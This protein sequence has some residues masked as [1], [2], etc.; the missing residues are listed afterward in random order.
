MEVRETT[1]NGITYRSRLEARWAV[2]FDK[3]GIKY[4][5]EPEGY[6]LDNGLNYLP[7]FYL[8]IAFTEG[9]DRAVTDYISGMSDEYATAM[10]ENLFIP[11]S[12]PVY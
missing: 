8:E 9:I 5:Y 10:F 12:W 2:F 6:K 1:Y 7:D 4:N 11:K 3:L